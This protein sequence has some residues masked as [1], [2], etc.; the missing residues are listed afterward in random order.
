[1]AMFGIGTRFNAA[2]SAQTFAASANVGR[3]SLKSYGNDTVGILL[4]HHKT[5]Q[6]AKIHPQITALRT[7]FACD[8]WRQSAFF[9]IFL[10]LEP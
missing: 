1:M 2:K 6:Q 7:D 8:S 9:R 5:S 10:H 4:L 3:P